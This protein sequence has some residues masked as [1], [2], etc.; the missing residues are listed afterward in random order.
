[1]PLV[2]Y[3]CI[4]PG[5]IHSEARIFTA[6]HQPY[7]NVLIISN[8]DRIKG[9]VSLSLRYHEDRPWDH[10][11][12][13]RL[14]HCRLG[15]TDTHNATFVDRDVAPL[16]RCYILAEAR[17][18]A[19]SAVYEEVNACSLTLPRAEV[20]VQ[21]QG[22]IAALSDPFVFLFEEDQSLG[23]RGR[24]TKIT[25]RR[26]KSSPRASIHVN[27][28]LGTRSLQSEPSYSR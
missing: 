16:D 18:G 9:V 25:R 21:A 5:W 23:W 20:R 17:G 14:P 6:D 4:I 11:H 7:G 15:E 8:F 3:R 24:V 10:C 1:M 22:E 12:C 13:R 19:V 2:E 26:L 28:R 27:L